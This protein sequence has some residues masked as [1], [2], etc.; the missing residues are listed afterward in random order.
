LTSHSS[1]YDIMDPK[2][3]E[4]VKEIL[5]DKN[6]IWG[7]MVEQGVI[8]TGLDAEQL[9]ASAAGL[10]SIYL[11]FGDQARIF[12]NCI[13][14]GIPLF[15]YVFAPQE[16]PKH[17]LMMIYCACYAVS[18]T[19][20]PALS[21]SI[22]AYYLVKIIA[23]FLLFLRPYCLAEKILKLSE[24]LQGKEKEEN[25]ANDHKLFSKD[26]LKKL[27]DRKAKSPPP[28]KP[29]GE[30]TKTSTTM[31]PWPQSREMKSIARSPPEHVRTAVSPSVSHQISDKP[32]GKGF[33]PS[34]SGNEM[35]DAP[36]NYRLES[37]SSE[38]SNGTPISP[39]DGRGVGA[40]DV[41]WE[42]R[43]KIIYNA[44]F[45][46][47]HLTYHIRMKNVSRFPVAF[48]IKS[49][50]IPRVT[51]TPCTGILKPGK[52]LYVAVT[53]QKMD[54]FDESL[55]VKDRIAFEYVRVPED[56][57]KFEFKL[58]QMS[59]LKLRKNI[60]IKYNP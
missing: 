57:P 2:A 3:V 9:V 5:H 8:A 46:Y 41:E 11:A 33:R 21:G 56:T 30:K 34:K 55:V 28:E 17:E 36:G 4:H 7:Q 58:L 37:S 29:E 1:S 15:V 40:Y 27:F 35:E 53:V 32:G 60:Y 14:I 16:K 12:A 47:A 50:A 23:H 48:A 44:P 10:I 38:T 22:P 24:Q 25:S 18:T 31:S 54:L 6:R 39:L 19:L 43:D 20:D 52:S 49:N 59:T 26:E 42:P 45:D 13:L 51:A